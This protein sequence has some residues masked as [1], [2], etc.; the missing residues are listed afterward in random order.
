MV[1][2]SAI[3]NTLESQH[4]I[5]LELI[6]Q[7][8]ISK[9]ELPEDVKSFMANN[10]NFRIFLLK[11]IQMK[12]GVIVAESSIFLFKEVLILINLYIKWKQL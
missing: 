12:M 3:L 7:L 10:H 8:Y 4:S 5:I 2:D 9:M 1:K 6:T 11:H